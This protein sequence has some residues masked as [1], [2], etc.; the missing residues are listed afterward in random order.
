MALF[1]FVASPLSTSLDVL[2]LAST[3]T[4]LDQ[5]VELCDMLLTIAHFLHI[6]TVH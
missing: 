1:A 2:E 4:R 3:I 6:I 5:F